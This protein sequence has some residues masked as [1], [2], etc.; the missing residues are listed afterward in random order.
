M[1]ICDVVFMGFCVLGGGFHGADVSE[2]AVFKAQVEGTNYRLLIYK[3]DVYG[4]PDLGKLNK[5]CEHDSCVWYNL[6]CVKSQELTC[7]YDI[8]NATKN[9]YR[10]LV[11]TTR[12]EA[13]LSAA[14]TEL[15]VVSN[16]IDNPIPLSRLDRRS[17]RRSLPV[18]GPDGC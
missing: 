1:S 12:D 2:G 9:Y 10:T 4:N 11:I 17:E 16:S 8:A 15:G 14:V 13:T 18:C 7:T 5:A 3:G 6:V